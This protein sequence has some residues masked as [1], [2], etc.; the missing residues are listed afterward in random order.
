MKWKGGGPPSEIDKRKGPEEGAAFRAPDC[1]LRLDFLSLFLFKY[2]GTR[3]SPAMTAGPRPGGVSVRW[4][5][6]EGGK[7]KEVIKIGSCRGPFGP[8]VAG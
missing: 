4:G 1:F 6:E 5:Q 7:V 2:I 3:G 8:Y